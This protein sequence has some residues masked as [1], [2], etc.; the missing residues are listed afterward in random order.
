MRR[1]GES[2][3]IVLGVGSISLVTQNPYTVGPNVQISVAQSSLQHYETQIAVDPGRADHLIACAYVT[4][5]ASVTDTAFYVSFD[6]GATWSHT[7]TVP[8]GVD[9]SCQVGLRGEAFAASIHDVTPPDGNSDS[10][11]VVHR[12]ADGGRT[13]TAARIAIDTRS[14]DRNYLTV[15][16]SRGPRRGR[17]YEHGYLAA[18][19]RRGW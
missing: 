1:L 17:I 2:L 12:S 13:W 4:R 3:A 14:V 16:D 7:L 5:S 9:P 15:D 10:F 19:Q 6:R 11:L 8:V 18:Q